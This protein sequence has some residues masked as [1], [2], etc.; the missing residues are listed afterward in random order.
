MYSSKGG[1]VES[2][3]EDVNKVFETLPRENQD[4]RR[5]SRLKTAKRVEKMGA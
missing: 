3:D 1:R 2:I 5:S 4:V